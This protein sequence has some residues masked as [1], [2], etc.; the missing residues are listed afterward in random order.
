MDGNQFFIIV[1]V[2][3]VAVVNTR[4]FII[5][6]V[7]IWNT[8]YIWIYLVWFLLAS[9]ILNWCLDFLLLPWNVSWSRSCRNNG[10]S[11]SDNW[12]SCCCSCNDWSSC[13]SSSYN[14]PCSSCNNLILFLRI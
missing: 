9:W 14:W 7:D 13:C 4:Q 12:P 10:N 1:L 11:G 2:I 3:Q 8:I 6:E 5:R